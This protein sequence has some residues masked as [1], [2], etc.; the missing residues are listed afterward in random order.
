MRGQPGTPTYSVNSWISNGLR[1]FWGIATVFRLAAV[2]FSKQYCLS[3]T[4]ARGGASCIAWASLETG[5]PKLSEALI[6]LWLLS[7]YQEKESNIALAG[8]KMNY[9]ILIKQE[10]TIYE[11][12]NTDKP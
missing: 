4:E 6:F 3:E 10:K 7:F 11:I 1:L 12:E 9:M 2:A 8:Q 5:A